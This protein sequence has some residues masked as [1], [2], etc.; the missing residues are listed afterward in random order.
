M[1]QLEVSKQ[2]TFLSI[3]GDP[4]CNFSTIFLPQIMYLGLSQILLKVLK[5]KLLSYMDINIWLL[6]NTFIQ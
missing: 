2:Y 1:G 4:K 6:H 3:L 5:F